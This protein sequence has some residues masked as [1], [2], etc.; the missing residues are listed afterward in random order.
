GLLNELTSITGEKTFSF[1]DASAPI[2]EKDSID[3]NKAYYKSRYEQ[4]DDSYINCA[5][6]KE[7]YERFYNELITAELANIHDF[8]TIYFEG[9][10]P[11]EAIAKRGEKTLRY[12]PLKPMGLGKTKDDRPYAVVQLRQDDVSASLY[13]IV[14]FQTNLTYSEQKRVFG[15]IPGLEN[16]RFV[17]YG[18]MHRNTFICAPLCL[19][20]NLSLKNNENVFIAGQLS[21]VEGYVESAATGLLAAIYAEKKAN[22]I[23]KE[24]ELIPVDTMLGCLINYITMCSPKNFSPMNSNFGIMYNV[25]KDKEEV[26]HKAIESL[27]RWWKKING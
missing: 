6:N 19:N 3:F 11:V 16:A 21:G 26:A 14:G 10:M 27:D 7:E 20:K 4:G 18:L 9:C 15:L 12:G 13:N 5:M 17:R 23:E 2:V 25:S 1:F 8:D 22:G 24:T